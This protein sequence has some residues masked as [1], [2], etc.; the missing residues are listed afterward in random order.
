VGSLEYPKGE[1][2]KRSV[3]CIDF[4]EFRKEANLNNLLT[5]CHKEIFREEIENFL[6]KCKQQEEDFEISNY[7]M[8]AM[9]NP[10]EF[11][12]SLKRQ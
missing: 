11:T 2:F 6:K 1:A 10:T 8:T 7:L 9:R 3:K 5:P 4:L 12:A